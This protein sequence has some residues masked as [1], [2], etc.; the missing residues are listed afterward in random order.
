MVVTWLKLEDDDPIILNL[1]LLNGVDK[2]VPNDQLA[3]IHSPRN[4]DMFGGIVSSTH[5]Q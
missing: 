5:I 2:A 3:L 4:G 1:N